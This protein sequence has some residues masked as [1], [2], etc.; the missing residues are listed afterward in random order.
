MPRPY[1]VTLLAVGVLTLAMVG[2]VRA[3]QSILLWDFL[4]KLEISPGYL[5]ASGL[6]FGLTGLPAVWGLWTG[7]PWTPRFTSVYVLAILVFFW[8]D[9]IFVVQSQISKINTPFALGISLFI[10]LYTVGVLFSPV[11]RDYFSTPRA[12]TS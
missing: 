12:E 1:S 6:L 2:I 9:R 7:R 10:L 8:I 4:T 5:L 11:G 3:W